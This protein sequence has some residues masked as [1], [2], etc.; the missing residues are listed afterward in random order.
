VWSA[1]RLAGL[2]SCLS[3][4]KAA[5]RSTS[6][7]KAWMVNLLADLFLWL[8]PALILVERHVVDS[9]SVVLD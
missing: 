3:A 9:I 6:V 5:S 2:V 8:S 4:A 7:P 1:G